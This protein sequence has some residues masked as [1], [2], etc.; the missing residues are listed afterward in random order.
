[1]FSVA[2][3]QL[4]SIGLY[5]PFYPPD[6]NEVN[7]VQ[8]LSGAGA[9]G[10]IGAAGAS[11]PIPTLKNP[12]V[13]GKGAIHDL[14]QSGMDKTTK[15][16]NAFLQKKLAP[17][18]GGSISGSG[19]PPGS[20]KQVASALAQRHG[21]GPSEVAAWYGVEQ[22]EDG[23][24]SLAATN[25]SSGAYGLAQFIN[26][27]SEY[28]TYGGNPGTIVGQLTAMANYIAGRYGTPSAALAHEI[29][30]NWYG[31]GG[32][33]P[34]FARGGRMSFR[35]PGFQGGGKHHHPKHRH[36]AAG[37][38]GYQAGSGSGNTAYGRHRHGNF[39]LPPVRKFPN[40]PYSDKLS[41]WDKQLAH[42]DSQY[43]QQE[44]IFNLYDDASGTL[45]IP[46]LN[47]L[48]G[49]R[50]QEWD[51][52]STEYKD[53]PSW[54]DHVQDLI[55]HIE[56][57]RHT[58][59]PG[60]VWGGPQAAKARNIA[61]TG[62]HVMQH[63]LKHDEH[64]IWTLQNHLSKYEQGGPAYRGK[65]PAKT[66]NT[67]RGLAG[68]LDRLL[69]QLHAKHNA[70]LHDT[71]RIDKLLTELQHNAGGTSDQYYKHLR[72]ELHKLQLNRQ[73]RN[74]EHATIGRLQD[75]HKKI[76]KAAKQYAKHGWDKAW[77]IVE[78]EW[79]LKDKINKLQQIIAELKKRLEKE[80]KILFGQPTALKNPRNATAGAY[81]LLNNLRDRLNGSP[82]GSVDPITTT[83]GG[84]VDIGMDILTLATQ[85]ADVPRSN[86]EQID[87]LL[88]RLGIKVPGSQGTGAGV[89]QGLAALQDFQ[90][91]QADRASLFQQFGSNF[92]A[93]GANP[94]AGAAGVA[95]GTQ[96][97]GAAAGPASGVPG[98]SGGGYLPG[99]QR[100][101]DTV[102]NITHNFGGAPDPHTYSAGLR[103][104]L[105]A[106]SV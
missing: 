63:E 5:R 58:Y 104:E 52:L 62:M 13:S 1:M 96:Y 2:E 66:M 68:Q 36:V 6:P 28:Y 41:G 19:I 49:I 34:G 29:S 60:N 65:V 73:S 37:G 46:D 105:G 9:T 81:G 45:P 55:H 10:A 20:W 78:H 32:R 4:R 94:F 48:Y 87:K 98:R 69:N 27:P 74:A 33:L 43:T 100:G 3:S 102:F 26:G 86:V 57:H 97:Y 91:F 76:Q 40:L 14:L 54:I 101:G 92:V 71:I 51:I 53:L 22:R 83:S 23:S 7:H 31:R 12:V 89:Q 95:A 80:N 93:A 106:L 44:N 8:L 59:W 72:R 35:I 11:R 15:A 21:W 88:R 38:G 18:A 16:A 103:H 75:L 61:R 50:K 17:L 90:A 84:M 64:E 82:D 79:R 25:P 77:E 47:L 85:G 99:A 70:S 24:L 56:G 30:N 67:A 39:H 42:L